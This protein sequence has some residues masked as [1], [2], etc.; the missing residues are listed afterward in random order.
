MLELCFKRERRRN[1][2][3][4]KGTK[5]GRHFWEVVHLIRVKKEG[6]LIGWGNFVQEYCFPLCV[7]AGYVCAGTV[8]E[9]RTAATTLVRSRCKR[10][11]LHSIR[12]WASRPWPTY[13][14]VHGKYQTVRG[15]PI[16]GVR[17]RV[18]LAGRIIPRRIAVSAGWRHRLAAQFDRTPRV[19][20]APPVLAVAVAL[21]PLRNVYRRTVKAAWRFWRS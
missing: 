14:E 8:V 16:L 21:A 5:D 7:Q 12:R 1:G 11:S 10:T 4:S 19:T 9:G 3:C 17:W 20:S 15:A 13:F 18:L 6:D 2:C